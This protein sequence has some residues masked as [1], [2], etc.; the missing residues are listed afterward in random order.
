MMDFG[1]ILRTIG[2]FGFFQKLVV[3]GLAFPDLLS[4]FLLQFSFYPAGSRATPEDGTF[5]RCQ[6]FVP[7]DWDIATIRE[8]GLNDTT[9]SVLIIL[10]VVLQFGLVCEKSNMTAVAQTVFMT[11][12]VAGSFIFGPMADLLVPSTQSNQR[13]T[14]LFLIQPPNPTTCIHTLNMIISHLFCRH[15]E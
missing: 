15:T 11:G 14:S 1:E 12:L 4:S 2:D 5:S 10:T 7:V 6:M 3:F 8:H 9:G 13:Y